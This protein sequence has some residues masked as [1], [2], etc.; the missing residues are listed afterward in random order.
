M[1]VTSGLEKVHTLQ[2]KAQA[3][4]I[5][6]AIH[7]NGKAKLT[8]TTERPASSNVVM[9]QQPRWVALHMRKQYFGENISLL[10]LI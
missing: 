8:P 10:A 2:S 3:V 4:N 7:E 5:E 9:S 6:L 1:F